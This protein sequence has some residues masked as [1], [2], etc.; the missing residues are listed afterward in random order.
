MVSVG[1][2]WGEGRPGPVLWVGTKPT[3]P[4]DRNLKG[5]SRAVN[6]RGT[7]CLPGVR[8]GSTRLPLA[9]CFLWALFKKEEVGAVRGGA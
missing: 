9:H 6:V 7:V 2:G 3:L 4:R 5:R 8:M 1:M